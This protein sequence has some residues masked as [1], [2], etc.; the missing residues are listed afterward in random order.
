MTFLFEWNR[1]VYARLFID[2]EGKHLRKI[3]KSLFITIII[4]VIAI[5]G[6]LFYRGKTYYDQITSQKSVETAVS[7]VMNSP[8]FVPYSDLPQIFVEATVDTEDHRFYEHDGLDYIGLL[9]AIVSQIIP[10]MPESGGSTIT[11]QTGKNLYGLF[12]SS[13]DR[14]AAEFFL[15][16]NLE[17]NY[18]KEEILAIYVNI[19]NYGDKNI[20]IYEASMNYFGVYPSQLNDAQATILAGIPQSP[21]YYQLSDHFDAAKIRQKAVL[22]A[23][24]KEKDI[25]KEEAEIIYNTPIY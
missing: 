21:S 10:G 13:L 22:N 9:R 4:F 7:E 12:Q 18:S 25:T 17:K 15:A 8:T 24:V 6:F 11:Q 2:E 16:K 23:M 3:F 14:K 1:K 20:G 19:I 5:S